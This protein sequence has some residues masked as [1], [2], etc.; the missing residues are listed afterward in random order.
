M[1]SGGRQRNSWPAVPWTSGGWSAWLLLYCGVLFFWSLGSNRALTDHEALLG[2]TVKTM[3]LTGDWLILRIGDHT[4]LEKPPLPQWLAGFS[5]IVC[6]E[7]DEWAMRLPFACA[8]VAVVFVQ[9]RL[10]R[11]WFGE[12]IG[13]LSGF[14]QAS[15][16]Y[17]VMYARLA[18]GDILLLLFVLGAIAAFWEAEW[19]RLSAAGAKIG[20]R[21]NAASI[22]QDGA[23][24]KADRAV[25]PAAAV[26]PW[27]FWVFWICL[28]L[29]SLV[30]GIGFGAALVVLTCVG[31]MVARGDARG[32][33]R[34]CSPTGWAITGGITF[35]WPLAVVWAE[36][37]ALA[38]WYE[39][40]LGRAAGTLGYTQ[41]WWYYFVQWPTQLLPWTPWFV[42]GAVPAA[43]IA[44]QDRRSPERLCGWWFLSQLLLLS[45]SSGKHHHYLIYALP[46]LAPIAAQGLLLC[47]RWLHDPQRPWW[48]WS[49]GLQAAAVV[50]VAGGVLLGLLKPDYRIDGWLF[51]PLLAVGAALLAQQIA[52]R[53]PARLVQLMLVVVA[54]GHVYAQ[55]AV[56]P[57]RDTSAADKQFLLQA[58]AMLPA[59]SLVAACGSQEI[60]RHV[61]YLKRPVIGVWNTAHLGAFLPKSRTCYVVARASA[62]DDLA[63]LGD[64][65]VCAQSRF[66][67]RET[68]PNDR[69]TLFR[70][71]PRVTT[72]AEWTVIRSSDSS[73]ASLLEPVAETGTQ[74]VPVSAIV[75]ES[76]PAPERATDP[77]QP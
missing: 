32:L 15:S 14:L 56:M 28:G 70:I 17:F 12:T 62:T 44:W 69:Y 35:A 53:Q 40:S 48:L 51:V 45:L 42:I 37:A 9:V 18:E 50:A 76:V 20:T 71:D 74:I 34:W 54:V 3:V 47:G 61:F 66:T 67:R 2:G 31:G 11:L 4:W 7:F 36:P 59:D 33:W 29:T 23:V 39:H 63:Y 16:V 64:V 49:R 27:S 24:E 5:A 30:K 73:A 8:A 57:R 25:S 55:T 75:P 77:T 26:R 38:L 46:A 13:W 10:M 65:T 43:R 41:P 22:E 21:L 58:D 1:D 60:A 52:R 6:G 68:S 72:A 19:G